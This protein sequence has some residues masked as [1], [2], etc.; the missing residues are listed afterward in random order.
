LNHVVQQGLLVESVIQR[1]REVEEVVQVLHKEKRHELR[2]IGPAVAVI[3][4]LRACRL[5]QEIRIIYS[6]WTATKR[7]KD[8]K[9]LETGNFLAM[10]SVDF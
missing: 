10:L 9:A 3:T 4:L 2:V 7:R 5:L 8:P 6:V 1:K